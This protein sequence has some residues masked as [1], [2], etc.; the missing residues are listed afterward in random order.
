MSF[1]A[2]GLT[3]AALDDDMVSVPAFGIPALKADAFTPDAAIAPPKITA[4]LPAMPLRNAFLLLSM[5]VPSIQ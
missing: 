5:P 4:N 1:G 3:A 2:S